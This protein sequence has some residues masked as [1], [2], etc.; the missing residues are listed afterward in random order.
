MLRARRR[1]FITFLGGALAS[2]LATLGQARA[3]RRLVAILSGTSPEFLS[4]HLNAFSKQMEALGRVE[5]RD[6]DVAVRF[7]M[8]DL[9][10]LPALAMEAVGLK[11]DIIVAANT[12]A[13]VA[14][15][16]ATSIIPIVSVALIE[17]V[18]KG[19]I[20]SYSHPGG[21]LTGILISLDTLLGKQLQIATELLP[22][23][24]K[25]GVLMNAH[26]ASSA[27]QRT[28]AEKVATAL[29]VELVV[30]DATIKDEIE[31]ALQQLASSRIDIA[32]IPTDPL[33]VNERERIAAVLAALRLPAVYGLRQHAE[34]GGLVS[35]GID[36]QANWRHTA[37]FVNRILRGSTPSDLPV[38]L[39]SK[40]ELVINL[41]T[42][43]GLGVEIPA[44]LIAR[45]DE[46]I[47]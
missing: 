22:A 9:S 8:G 21:N 14:A 3:S 26:S 31:A 18:K 24:K 46:V 37:D 41:K 30:V 32:I 20:A 42:A 16:D 7:A 34:V 28:D 17:P 11:P 29:G 23:I 2:S 36:L 4:S 27:I 45:A 19:L 40:L 15:R 38:E 13:A 43:K 12:T 35:Y 5:G 1:D 10:R 25:A 33:F 44:A 47:E 6:Y 39:P